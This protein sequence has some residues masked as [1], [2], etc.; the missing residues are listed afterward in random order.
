MIQAEIDQLFQEGHAQTQ[1]WSNFENT[2]C[3]G[4]F[5]YKVYVIANLLTTCMFCLQ[6]NVSMQVWWRKP[7]WFGRQS[8]EKVD[9]TFIKLMALKMR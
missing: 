5:E 1:F 9:F 4:N 6:N 2:K 7:H 3:C 8:S